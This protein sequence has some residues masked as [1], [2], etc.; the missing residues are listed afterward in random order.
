MRLRRRRESEIDVLTSSSEVST[1]PTQSGV[2]NNKWGEIEIGNVISGIAAGLKPQ[3]T[4]VGDALYIN[5]IAGVIANSYL[6]TIRY[7]RKPFT[8][9]Q[10]NLDNSLS[11][12]ILYNSGSNEFALSMSTV[13]GALDGFFLGQNVEA[14]TRQYSELR[15]SQIIDMYYSPRGVFN[16]SIKACNRKTLQPNAL[17]ESALVN[18][19]G[20]FMYHLNNKIA[21]SSMSLENAYDEAQKLVKEYISYLGK[22][23][24]VILE[25]SKFL[26]MS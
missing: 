10:E 5:T 23:V 1:C 22:C 21:V 20:T 8:S 18:E 17:T 6:Y 24:T 3:Q 7:D 15:I 4:S 13:R 26:S 19:T 2:V 14:W 12:K 9:S 11:P 25:N 16:N